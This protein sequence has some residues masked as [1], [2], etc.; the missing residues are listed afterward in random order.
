[1]RGWQ[2]KSHISQINARL[3]NQFNSKNIELTTTVWW[4]KIADEQWDP[5]CF[6]NCKRSMREELMPENDLTPSA[7][8][9][10][11]LVYTIISLSI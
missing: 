7:I 6:P 9:N 4:T 1:M 5:S 11:S 10:S 8:L 3:V 2:T